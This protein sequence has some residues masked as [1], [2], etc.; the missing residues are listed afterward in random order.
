MFVWTMRRAGE[1]T[2]DND[3]IEPSRFVVHRHVDDGGTHLDLRIETDGGGLAGWRLSPD[4]IERTNHGDEVFCLAKPIHP[5]RWLDH[6]S[7]LCAVVGSGRCRRMDSEKGHARMAFDGTGLNGIYEFRPWPGERGIVGLIDAVERFAGG[8]A[9]GPA[10]IERFAAAAEDG[11]TARVRAIERVCGLGRELDG[12]AFD[13][14][15]W[16]SMLAPLTL[17]EVY[18]QMARFERRFDEKYPPT[19]VTR[20]D[21]SHDATMRKREVAAILDES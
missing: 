6:N 15:L 13:E 20:P 5:V 16:R 21:K 18:R 17:N 14:R 12:D 3:A 2:A 19:G 10:D 8:T 11:R 1:Y 4:A 9:A 7:E